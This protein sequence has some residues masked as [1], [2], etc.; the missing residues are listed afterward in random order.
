MAI[1]GNVVLSRQQAFT[2]V[3]IYV[4]NQYPHPCHSIAVEGNSVKWINKAGEPNSF[5]D[6]EN[7]GTI[8][9]VERNNFSADL[10]PA[11]ANDQAPAECKCLTQGR[12]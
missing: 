4:W 10:S 6:G 9:G 1:R 8:A 11:I 3:G 7:C 12:R 2:N 5:W